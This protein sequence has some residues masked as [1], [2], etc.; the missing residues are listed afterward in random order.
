MIKKSYEELLLGSKN[1]K[2]LSGEVTYKERKKPEYKEGTETSTLAGYLK[3][4]YPDLPFETVKH[5]GKKQYWEQN[6]HK[7]QNSED[8]FADTRIYFPDFTLMIEQKKFGTKLTL[9]DGETLAS[10]HLQD[11]YNTIKRLFCAHRK[12][13]FAVGISEAITLVIQGVNGCLPP[14]Q[15]FKD[16]SDKIVDTLF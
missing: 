16:R 10:E 8:S 5:E 7:K 6:Q 15:F 14:M 11:Q 12:C 3:K 13:Y 2:I 9:K 1:A 4:N